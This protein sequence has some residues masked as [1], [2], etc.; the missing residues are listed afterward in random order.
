MDRYVMAVGAAGQELEDR[1]K[2][3]VFI[4]YSRKDLAFADQLDAALRKRGFEP[5]IDRTDIYAF[6]EWWKRVQSLIGRADTVVFVLSP[7]AVRPESVARKE[8]E[9]AASLNKR[10]APIVF[11]PV[12]DK[13][14]P[15]EL[16]KLNFIFFEDPTRFDQSAD[17]LAEALNTDIAW[18]RQHTEF[19]EAARRWALAKG[20]SGLLLRPPLLDQAEAWLAYRPRE[21]PAPTAET[22][23]FI[24]ASRKAE[25]AA[26]RRSR[27]LNVAL[28]TLLVSIILGLVGWINQSA[29]AAQWRYLTVTWPYARANVRSYVLNTAKE[30]AL[31]PGQSFK[32]CAQDCPEMIVVPAG[33]FTMGSPPIEQGRR[34]SEGPQHAVT[35]ARPFAVSKYELTFADWDA[36]VTGG[37]CSGYRPNDAGFGRGQ[38]RPSIYVSWDDAQQYVAWLSEVTGKTYRLL[39][40]AE[41]EYAARAGTTTAYPWGDDI[42]LNDIA[43]ANCDGCGSKWDM[44]QPAPIG[45]FPPNKFGLY[46]VVGNL[47]EW[48][49]DCA[50]DDY[51]GAPMDGSPWTEGGDCSKRIV[52]AG[53]FINTLKD[54]RSA[55]HYATVPNIRSGYFGIR[56][57]RTLDVT[58]TPQQIEQVEQQK[59]EQQKV[60]QQH[61]WCDDEKNEFSL[62]LQIVGCTALIQSGKL[63]DVELTRAYRGRAIA[64]YQKGDYD[65]AIADLSEL[66]KLNPN[67]ADYYNYRGDVYALKGDYDRAVTDYSEV[68]KL[69][70]KSAAAYNNRCFGRAVIGRDLQNALADCNESLVLRPNDPGTLNSRGLVQYKLGAFQEAIADY[71]AAITQNA[72]DANSLYGR[73]MAKLKIGDPAGGSTDI[74]AAEAIESNIAKVYVGYGVNQD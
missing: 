7:D 1:S 13:A 58:M 19:G 27:I 22:E 15:E 5:L 57:G 34:T 30:Q 73:G 70:P 48:T 36:C 11:R 71:T 10:F 62:D 16:A 55:F 68:I 8:V 46:D 23:A 35:I 31:S 33:S 69:D 60:H 29:I 74:V 61:R 47:W 56:V 3:K 17:R 49:E 38:Q 26:R 66:I 63:S 42:K 21:A 52:R 39:S 54:I 43:M 50:H 32:E 6:E 25:L 28:Y 44:V 41:Y 64:Y 12:D 65:N 37:G 14:V 53:S 67:S 59:A 51:N 72:K 45:S 9:F 40:N 18:I 4:S 20:P 24:R 2:A